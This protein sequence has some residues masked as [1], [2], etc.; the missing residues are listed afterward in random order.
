MSMNGQPIDRIISRKFVETII[1]ILF[2]IALI[3]II[4]LF[5]TGIVYNTQDTNQAMYYYISALSVFLGCYI[6]LSFPF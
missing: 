4:A 2:V 5:I 3:A 1:V 6:F